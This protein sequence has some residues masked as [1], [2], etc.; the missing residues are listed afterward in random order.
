MAPPRYVKMA[1]PNAG[2]KNLIAGAPPE[3]ELLQVL[4]RIGFSDVAVRDR[5]DPFRATTKEKVARKFGVVDVNV[6]ATKR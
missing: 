2:H 3:G 5:F 6:L 4:T 1:W